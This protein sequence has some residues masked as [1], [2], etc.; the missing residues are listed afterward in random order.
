MSLDCTLDVNARKWRPYQLLAGLGA[1]SLSGYFQV[2]SRRVCD[3]LFEIVKAV[4]SFKLV[5]AEVR[6]RV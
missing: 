6:V 2:V 4:G 5:T 1:Q 3:S